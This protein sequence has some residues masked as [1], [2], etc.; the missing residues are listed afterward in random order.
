MFIFDFLFSKQRL[1]NLW[2][3]IVKVAAVNNAIGF[4]PEMFYVRLSVMVLIALSLKTHCL[5]LFIPQ[6]QYPF[7]AE[8]H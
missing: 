7:A 5:A 6:L 1:E 2:Q 3:W 8:T 4:L